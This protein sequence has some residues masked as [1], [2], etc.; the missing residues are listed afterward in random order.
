MLRRLIPRRLYSVKGEPNFLESVEIFFNKAAPH[1]GVRE[2]TLSHIKATDSLLAVTFPIEKPDGTVEVIR[3]YRA[4]HSR[5][6][7]PV[8]GGIRYAEDVDMQEVEA[9]ASLMTFKNAIVD[10]PFGGAKGGVKIDPKKY[11]EQTLERITRRFT[12]ELCQRNFIG[13]GVDVPAPDMGTGG[14]EMSWVL[15]TYRQFFPTDVN[16]L[17]CVTGKPVSQGGVRGRT[18]ATG[19]GVYFCIR[20]FLSYKEIQKQTGLKGTI[21][22]LKVIV[23]GFGNVGYYASQ[24][25]HTNGAK[26]LGVAE[27][28]GGIYNPNGLD[29][30][31]LLQYRKQHKT[32]EGFPG[33]EFIP[34]SISLLERECDVL[35]PCALEQQ[36]HGQNAPNI[37]AKLIAEG[38]NG[39][40]TPKGHDILIANGKVIIPD[41]LCNSGGVTVSY[42]EWLKNLSHVRFGRMNKRWDEQG[43]S[44]IVELVEE[45]AG[46]KLATHERNQIIHGA[47]EQD[48]VYSGLEDTLMVAC[49]E[50]HKTSLI[51]NIDHRM[52]ALS[53]AISK[54]ATSY[55]G[56]GMIF[57]Q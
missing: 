42:F 36:I 40:I 8:K 21:E 22:D 38:A 7:T 54:I 37:K 2:G 49:K 16:A 20:E 43:K 19:L 53:N 44:R 56:S 57:M 6:R 31:A 11:D 4:Q 18:E 14:R 30:P 28:N 51:K 46:R 1:A 47:E 26:I 5:H 27:F 32:F 41:A 39:P 45:V 48:L 55:E 29:I 12:M 35:V 9:L 34:D 15:D 24:F 23:Q 33:G 13:P 50:T 52:A 17:G 3:A 25:L 10:V